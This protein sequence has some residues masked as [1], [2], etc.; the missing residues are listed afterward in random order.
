MEATLYHANQ[1]LKKQTHTK[2]KQLS[3]FGTVEWMEMIMFDLDIRNLP[4]VSSC[5]PI[6]GNHNDYYECFTFIGC[7]DNDC[8][9]G[10]C[11]QG[12]QLWKHQEE[13]ISQHSILGTDSCVWPQVLEWVLYLPKI[14]QM[15]L[16]KLIIF[17]FHK[18][19]WHGLQTILL[20]NND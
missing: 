10:V 3:S 20:W 15:P 1:V 12:V 18:T 11:S 7:Q 9:E 16:T 5:C 13:I 2:P 6:I 17:F 8:C 14:K 4:K 19:F